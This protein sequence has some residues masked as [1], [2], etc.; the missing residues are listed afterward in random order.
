VA[1]FGDLA[2]IE[3]AAVVLERIVPSEAASVQTDTHE[4]SARCFPMTV[5]RGG[6]S[7]TLGSTPP[8]AERRKPQ[9]TSRTAL[10]AGRRQRLGA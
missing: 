9:W 6:G 5:T 7:R 1:R 10:D 3:E 4:Y 8:S 2:F